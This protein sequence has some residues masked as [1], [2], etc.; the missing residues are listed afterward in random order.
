MNIIKIVEN[1][2]CGNENPWPV[3]EPI[4]RGIRNAKFLGKMPVWSW[5]TLG[6]T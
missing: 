1:R 3:K 2:M 4:Y 6:Q 5:E